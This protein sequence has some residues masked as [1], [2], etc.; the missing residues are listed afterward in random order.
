MSAGVHDPL[1]GVTKAVVAICVVLVPIAAVG[2]T[3]VPVSVGEPIV[4]EL[5]VGVPPSV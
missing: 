1:A 2:A 5:I 3:G 4:G